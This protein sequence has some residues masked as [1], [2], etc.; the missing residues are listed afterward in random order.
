VTRE[1]NRAL[2]RGVKIDIIVGDKTANDFYIPPSEPFKVIAA[3]PY[4]YEIS[5]RRFA[6]RHQRMIDSGQLNLHLWRDGDNTYHLKGMWVDQRYTLL[7]GNNLNPRA[8]RLDLENALLLDDP[9]GELLEP[10][11]RELTEIFEHTRRIEHFQN[12]ETL[13][14]YPEAVGKFLRRV[15]RVRIERLLY[16]IL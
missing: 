1:V 4:L 14:D 9:K 10:R 6:K 16:R 8:F 15:S 3:L 2:A 7:T 5:L 12:L 13:V 11:Q